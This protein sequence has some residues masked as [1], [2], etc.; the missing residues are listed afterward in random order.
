MKTWFA[1]TAVSLVVV[2][3]AAAAVDAV[4]TEIR[5]TSL[6]VVCAN[7][8]RQAGREDSS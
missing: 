2:F 5:L 4:L 7:K 8:G 1:F 3:V 6:T